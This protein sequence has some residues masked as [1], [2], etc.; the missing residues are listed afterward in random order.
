[1]LEAWLR[2]LWGIYGSKYLKSSGNFVGET[3][4]KSKS[5]A[6]ELL[7]RLTDQYRSYLSRLMFLQAEDS[8]IFEQ[9]CTG[10][11]RMLQNNGLD[12]FH[13]DVS[14]LCLR[15]EVRKPLSNEMPQSNKDSRR[16]KM[17]KLRFGFMPTSTLSTLKLVQKGYQ[18]SRSLAYNTSETSYP[19]SSVSRRQYISIKL[20][21]LQQRPGSYLFLP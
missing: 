21:L 2:R 8:N 12:K 9:S 5:D 14:T 7:M 10:A 18:C 1:M 6:E 13:M 17:Q 15:F 11:L 16:K 20:S 3:E 19:P 4:R